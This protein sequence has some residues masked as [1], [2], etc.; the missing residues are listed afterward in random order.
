MLTK[1]LSIIFVFIIS[2]SCSCDDD[3]A[4]SCERSVEINEIA[5]TDAPD[6]KVNILES[7]IDGDCLRLKFGTS[8]CSEEGWNVRLIDADIIMKSLPVQRNIRLSVTGTGLCEVY[9]T[10]E[11]TFDLSEIQLDTENTINLNLKNSGDVI[12][13]NY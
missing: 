5:Y 6:W 2:I 4:I 7:E 12:Q 8:G 11:M 13:Y 10:K 3:N 9:F 1:I